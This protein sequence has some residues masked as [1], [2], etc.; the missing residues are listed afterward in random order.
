MYGLYQTLSAGEVNSQFPKSACEKL[1][2][3]I[4]KVCTTGTEM[5]KETIFMLM[6]EHARVHGDYVY[7]PDSNI[8]RLPYL[9]QV[10]DSSNIV[11]DIYNLP[12]SLKGILQK[13][14]HFLEEEQR[15]QNL[16]PQN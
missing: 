15:Q 5:E 11:F 16:Q 6:C 1:H 12:D 3:R 9:I 7:S 4:V 8:D 13:Y 10:D 14:L 2:E